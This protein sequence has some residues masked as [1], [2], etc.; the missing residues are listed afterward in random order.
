MT[1]KIK[2]ILLLLSLSITLSFMSN[3]YSRYVVDATGNV[4]VEFAKWQI[5]VSDTDITNGATST[6]ELTPVVDENEH[7]A[8]GTIAP[9]SKGHFDIVIN[10]ENVGVS[11]D[12]EISLDVLN[13]NMPDLMITEYSKL[14]IDYV[15]GTKADVKTV[16]DNLITETLL[17]DNSELEEGEEPFKFEPFKIRVYFEWYE[18]ENELMDDEADTLIGASEEETTLNIEATIKFTQKI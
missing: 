8:K 15:E 17:Y 18:G 3:T 6:I 16:E 1:R 14:P 12:Y 4:K 5:L 2:I 10:P 13:D 11:F 7:V 9:T